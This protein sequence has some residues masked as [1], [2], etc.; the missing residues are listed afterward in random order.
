M[1]PKS[2]GCWLVSVLIVFSLLTPL[3]ARAGSGPI[4][5][6]FDMEDRGSKLDKE[7]LSNLIDY[8]AARL[9]EG[10]FQVV[11]TDQIRERLKSSKS[12]SHKLCYDQGCQIDLGRELSAQK[13]LST[14]I[15]RI[16]D[17]CQVTA[18]MYDLKKAT[19]ETAATAEAVCEVNKLL[20]AVK[21]I[22]VSLCAPLKHARKEADAKLAEYDEL[23][24]NAASEKAEKERAEK[25]WQKVLSIA[26][27]DQV[28]TDK[29]VQALQK[30]RQDFQKPNPHL[31]EVENYLSELNL[32]TLIVRTVP[33]GAAVSIGG[34]PA[35]KSPVTYKLKAGTYK[36]VAKLNG[37][38]DTSSEA[39]LESGKNLE[40]KL[41]LSKKQASDQVTG[42]SS[43]DE[44]PGMVTKS[45]PE[46]PMPAM[47]FWGHVAFWSGIGVA[48]LAGASAALAAS[49]GSDADKVDQSKMWGGIFWASTAVAVGLISTGVVLWVLAPDEGSPSTTAA[50]GPT[51][52][53]QGMVFSLGGRW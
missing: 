2:L 19:T 24:K 45:L 13:T 37:Y 23:V 10:G 9:T 31:G 44:H 47:K 29:R 36:L 12:E 17:T 14:K 3:S 50:I 1:I 38:N 6:L 53:G 11:P 52:D 48:G 26:R 4:V 22:A 43:A 46:K 7:V 30:Y 34:K 15:L 35:K 28:P 33:V 42:T 32:G 40:L 8:L 18:V 25:A 5:A 39:K 20:A 21:K 41:T 27:D 51:L 16:G 49:Y